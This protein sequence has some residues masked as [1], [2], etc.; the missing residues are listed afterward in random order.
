MA[1]DLEHRVQKLEG[2]GD[3]EGF[4]IR[5]VY[6][7]TILDPLTGERHEVELVFPDSAYTITSEFDCDQGHVR[8]FDLRPRS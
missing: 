7:R 6:C 2:S 5:F 4:D 8:V 3:P 1:D